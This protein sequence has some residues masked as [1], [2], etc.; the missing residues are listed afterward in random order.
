MSSKRAQP[1]KEVAA[2]VRTTEDTKAT[3][4][5]EIW[6]T[7]DVNKSEELEVRS[8]TEHATKKPLEEEVGATDKVQTADNA[9]KE[10][11]KLE[12]EEEKRQRT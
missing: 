8:T 2:A 11:K 9:L 7:D 4:E 1:A 12:M 6:A 5:S 3:E 10:S